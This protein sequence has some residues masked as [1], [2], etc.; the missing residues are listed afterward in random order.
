MGIAIS[1]SP[2][3]QETVCV[4]SLELPLFPVPRLLFA[5]PS[6]PAQVSL[7]ESQSKLVSHAWH[8]QFPHL[9]FLSC[10]MEATCLKVLRGWCVTLLIRLGSIT[11]CQ[12]RQT[13]SCKDLMYGW[14][15]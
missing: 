9:Q 2:E 12:L 8:N 14:A 4:P 11:R 1:W 7:A 3:T 13:W 10:R 5:I 15:F 6:A